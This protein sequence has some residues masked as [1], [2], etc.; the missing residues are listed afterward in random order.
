MPTTLTPAQKVAAYIKLRDFKKQA[1]DEFKKSLERPIAAMDKLE[2]EL[3]DELTKMG[4]NSL[5]CDKG[6]VYKNTQLSATV[7]DR[8]AFKGFCEM[9]DAWEAIDI[10]ANKTFIKEYMEKTQEVP[11]GLK[12]TQLST[13]GIRRS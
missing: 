10:K 9:N 5:S 12:V 6:T 8:E 13:V 4:V 11:P 7:I 3:L 1:E 2:A